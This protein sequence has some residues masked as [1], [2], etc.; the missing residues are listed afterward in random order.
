MSEKIRFTPFMR[1]CLVAA[2]VSINMVGFGCTAGFP[3]IMLPQLQEPGSTISVT[4]DQAS[5]LA[6]VGSITLVFGT[7]NVPSIMSRYGRKVAL[8]AAT[9]V[10]ILAWCCYMLATSYGV[11]L[12]GA[13]A[14]GF[15]FG[16][17]APLRSIYV[18]ECSSP[19]YRGG[20][21]AICIE[22]QIFG[23]LIVHLTGSF[24]SYQLTALYSMSFPV[25]SLV[26][27]IYSPES[28]SWLA[29]KGQY[30]KCRQNFL[31]LRGEEEIPE[32]ED[33]IQAANVLQN[34]SLSTVKEIIEVVKKKEY[35]KPIIVMFALYIIIPCTGGL[36]T[37]IYGVT[38]LKILMGPE[39]NANLWMVGL[40]C[41]RVVTTGI[42]VFVINKVK[43]RKLLFSVGS[44]CVGSQICLGAYM[45]L[46]N[47]GL[48]PLNLWIPGVLISVQ[49][50][51]ISLGM[52]PLPGVIAGEVYPL[53]HRGLAGSIGLIMLSISVFSVLKGYMS[54]ISMIG[55]EGI[56]FLFSLVITFCLMVVWVLLP[57][58]SGRTLQE[59][60]DHFRAPLLEADERQPL[61]RSVTAS[62]LSINEKRCVR[63]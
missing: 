32:C 28:P 18:G 20:L 59:V 44:L 50:L 42:T 11:L 47:N 39:V 24:I 4:K 22:S 61:T 35:F 36:P 15:S 33:M 58:T 49:M 10:S 23:V 30:D 16:M 43:R 25:I 54:L 17:I 8:Y 48:I 12:L 26:I 57:E 31:W 9:V 34:S 41:V 19:R 29:T 38:I 5:W 62:Y 3:G 45:I 37:A 52:Q 2:A 51:S 46:R 13:M 1:Q 7:F 27:F 53:Q 60:E 56:Y 63:V 55:L 14:H 6:S 21:L 40:D